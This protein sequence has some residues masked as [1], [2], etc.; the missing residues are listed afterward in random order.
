LD[1][2]VYSLVG[3]VEAKVFLD[4]VKLQFPYVSSIAATEIEKS[5]GIVRTH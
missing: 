2:S 5:E 3:D 1:G 4:A